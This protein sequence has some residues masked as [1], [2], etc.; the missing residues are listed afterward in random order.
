MKMKALTFA[1]VVV[2]CALTATIALAQP[3]GDM[4]DGPRPVSNTIIVTDSGREYDCGDKDNSNFIPTVKLVE[5]GGKGVV[6]CGGVQIVVGKI[7]SV[8]M[9]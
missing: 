6:D 7:E 9:Q 4:G 2:G 3:R 5:G 1:T 8:R